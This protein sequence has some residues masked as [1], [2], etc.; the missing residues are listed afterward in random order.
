MTTDFFQLSRI[1]QISRHS[2]NTSR[3]YQI[4][5]TV[6]PLLFDNNGCIYLIFIQS[7]LQLRGAAETSLPA[8]VLGFSFRLRIGALTTSCG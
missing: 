3:V 5:L 8:L 7:S 4:K 1:L 2:Y 6:Q